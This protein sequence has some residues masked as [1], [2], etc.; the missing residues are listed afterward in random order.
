[1]RRPGLSAPWR[2]AARLRRL[3]AATA[4]RLSTKALT[5][6]TLTVACLLVRTALGPDVAHATVPAALPRVEARIGALVLDAPP[7]QQRALDALA[8]RAR[9]LL[10]ALETNLGAELTAP[11]RLRLIP[12]GAPSDSEMVRLE[13]AAPPWAAGFVIP[14]ARIGAIRMATAVRYPYGTLE[15]VLAHEATHMILHDAVGRPLPRWFDEGVATW[16][17][18]RWSLEDAWV[19]SAAM[20]RDDVP[21]LE[22]LDR[23]FS[24]SAPQ[25]REAYAASFSFVSWAQAAYGDDLIRDV[26]RAC[27]H[28][29]FE[30]AWSDRAGSTL[31]ESERSW[32]RENM[33]RV[34]WIAFLVAS[35]VLWIGIT[36]LA[37]IAG[38][39]RRRRARRTRAAMPDLEPLEELVEAAPPEPRPMEPGP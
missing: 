37:L 26:V 18:R 22:S 35:N 17:G 25:A 24:A 12:P 13:A 28:R 27:R 9:V 21:P 8:A 11:W 19:F 31:Y 23:A 34:R 15:S 1:M 4:R 7:A 20:L 29:R 30:L 3:P 32:R 16:E 6:L 2:G 38:I 10:P 33:S 5:W 14:G 39:V 36:L